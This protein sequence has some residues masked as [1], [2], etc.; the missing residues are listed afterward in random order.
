MAV[1]MWK[2]FSFSKQLFAQ[3]YSQ[4][5]LAL[6]VTAFFPQSSGIISDP[7][8]DECV[9]SVNN[10]RGEDTVRL[11]RPLFHLEAGWGAG[12]GARAG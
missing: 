7:C 3:L 10:K 4:V 6:S 12:S 2:H 9:V 11:T 5:E 1:F 8:L